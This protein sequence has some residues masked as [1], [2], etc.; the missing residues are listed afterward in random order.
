[1]TAPRRT[2][3]F[4]DA[5]EA[6]HARVLVGDEVF[7]LPEEFLPEGAK[8]GAWIEVAVALVTP[9]DGGDD[10]TDARRRRLTA[11]DDGGDLDL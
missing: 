11:G 4:V 7:S 9:P 2:R 1:M 5:I 3:A 6:G 10:E 8:E